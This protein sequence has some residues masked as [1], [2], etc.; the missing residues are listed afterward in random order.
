MIRKTPQR[1]IGATTSD[2]LKQVRQDIGADAI[3]LS[4]RDT[5]KGVEIIAISPAAI[6][7]MSGTAAPP[8]TALAPRPAQDNAQHEKLFTLLSEVKEL[9][10]SRVAASEWASISE[11][12]V[13]AAEALRMMLNAGFSEDVSG[14]VADEFKAQQSSRLTPLA[15]RLQS[16]VEQ[17]VRRVDALE[18]FDQGGIFPLIGS[19]GVGKTTVAAK[20][21]ARCALRYGRDNVALLTTDTFRIGAQ[22]QIRVYSRIIGIPMAAVSDSDDLTNKL[23]EFSNRK[24]ILVDTAGM[25]QRDLKMLE[26]IKL[27]KS[28]AESAHHILVL[29]STANLNTLEDVILMYSQALQADRDSQIHSVIITKTDEAAQLGPVLDCVMRHNLPLLFLANGQQ[30][31]EDLSPADVP[32]LVYRALHPRLVGQGLEYSSANV[33]LLMMDQLTAWAARRSS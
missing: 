27:L 22:D 10:R 20:I 13:D 25:G 24:V 1:F 7:S 18:T 8:P 28:G 32:Y 14:S 11:N 12:D 17:R 6:A 19:T 4:T 2:A 5:P 23:E 30:V 3:V 16:L 31:P 29:S 15:E 9:I 21:A 33:P 26:Q